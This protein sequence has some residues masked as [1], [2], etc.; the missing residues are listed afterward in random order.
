MMPLIGLELQLKHEIQLLA[1]HEPK[2]I[3]EMKF[4]NVS[5][6][7]IMLDSRVVCTGKEKAKTSKPSLRSKLFNT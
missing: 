6:K 5:R 7:I 3:P 2:H 4:S 1:K